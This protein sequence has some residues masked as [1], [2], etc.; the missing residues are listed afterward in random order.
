M[1]IEDYEVQTRKA[2]M[3]E[4]VNGF[5]YELK[6]ASD[7]DD[8]SVQLIWKKVVEKDCI[9]VNVFHWM[10][11]FCF[12]RYLMTCLCPYSVLVLSLHYFILP[13]RRICN[14]HCLSVCLLETLHKN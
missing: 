6:E 9:K 4:F 11:L 7:K 2:L 14:H 3:G 8:K 1:D 13:P 5:E 12:S 10:L